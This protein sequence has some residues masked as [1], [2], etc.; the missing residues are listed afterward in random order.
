M[1]A[2][3]YGRE[4]DHHLTACGARFDMY[5][6][7]AAHRTLPLGTI[8]DVRNPAND[9][10][11]RV[12]VIDRG[13]YAH[14]RDLDLSYAAAR[15]LD[16]LTQG[17]ARVYVSEVGHDSRYDHYWQKGVEPKPTSTPNAAPGSAPKEHLADVST[18]T[19][20]RDALVR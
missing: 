9:K 19:P 2:S 10:S 14:G 15:D 17:L 6:F 1:V 8:L 18:A 3:W 16:I 11:V 4:Q 5:A 7:T 13:P 20:S 12:T